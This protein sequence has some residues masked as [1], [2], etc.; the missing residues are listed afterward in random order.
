M[1]SMSEKLGSPVGMLRK[2]R[3]KDY[4]VVTN[5]KGL[6]TRPATELVR[7]ASSYHAQIQLVY[8]GLKVN[9]KSML[10]ILM[11]AAPKG[12]KVVVEAE[13]EDAESAMKDILCRAKNRFNIQY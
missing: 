2:N 7:C 8:Q 10:G 5:E 3:F 13:G 12:A 4:F 11:L 6:H 1:L 9:A